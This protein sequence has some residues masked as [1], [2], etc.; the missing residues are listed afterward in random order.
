MKD[1]MRY[2]ARQVPLMLGKLL[3]GILAVIG[4]GGLVF[5]S[6]RPPKPTTLSIVLH[7]IAGIVGIT[8]F[9]LCSR[10]MSSRCAREALDEAGRKQT[11][12]KALSWIILLALAAIFI[13][14]ML[15]VSG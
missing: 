9:A 15:L 2:E 11:G 8:V 13:V 3:G 1:D 6:T 10:I 12:A 4:F 14:I 7:L 5:I